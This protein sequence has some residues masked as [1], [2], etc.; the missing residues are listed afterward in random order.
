LNQFI[1]ITSLAPILAETVASGRSAE[2]TVT[3]HSMDPL[4][5]DRKSR[6]R[7]TAP[8]EPKRGD[9]VFYKRDD[10]KYVLHRVVRREADGTYTICGD[11]QYILERG[12]RPDQIFARVEAFAR[13]EKWISCDALLYRVWWNLRLIDRPIRS[14]VIHGWRWV[15]RKV[16][17]LIF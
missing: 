13:R 10:G 7:L 15:K 2:I 1:S 17:K 5:I 11:A 9:M 4:L 6:V 12:I 16:K 3:G 14:F 8:G